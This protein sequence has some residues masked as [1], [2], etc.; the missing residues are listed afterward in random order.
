VTAIH[1]EAQ[2]RAYNSLRGSVE[3]LPLSHR[4]SGGHS[5]H[6]YLSAGLTIHASYSLRGLVQG[7]LFT[8]SSVQAYYSLGVYFWQAIYNI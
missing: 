1:S 6:S 8:H 4:H 2:C 7:I 5:I 3:S